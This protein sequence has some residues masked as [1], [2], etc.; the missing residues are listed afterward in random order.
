MMEVEKRRVARG[1]K[2]IIFRRGRGINIVFGPKYR[3]LFFLEICY[4]RLNKRLNLLL[5]LSACVSES[6]VLV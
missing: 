4:L 2:N 1:G 3:P 6:L 5:G